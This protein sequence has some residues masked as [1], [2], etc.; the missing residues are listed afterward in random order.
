MVCQLVST[1]ACTIKQ[2]INF[3]KTHL[4]KKC[5]LQLSKYIHVI[6]FSSSLFVMLYSYFP[7]KDAIIH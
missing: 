4:E 2:P 1:F 5:G 3:T 7:F 6:F